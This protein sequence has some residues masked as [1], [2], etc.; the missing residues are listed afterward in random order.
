MEKYF[1]VIEKLQ[2][3]YGHDQ[4]VL[5]VATLTELALQEHF[6]GEMTDREYYEICCAGAKALYADDE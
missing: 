1:R 2:T 3:I 6:A 5:A 4:L